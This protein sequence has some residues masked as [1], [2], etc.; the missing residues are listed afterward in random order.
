VADQCGSGCTVSSVRIKADY[1]SMKTRG[2][3]AAWAGLR[4]WEIEVYGRELGKPIPDVIS[5]EEPVQHFHNGGFKE[6]LGQSFEIAAEV[7]NLERSVLITG[8]SET[9]EE[10]KQGIHTALMG[11]GVVDMRYARLE[12]CGQRDKMGRY[13]M[14]FHQAERCPDCRY[15]GNAVVNSAQAAITL[16]GSHQ[17]LVDSNIIWKSFGAG[18]Y[19]EDGNEMNN[20]ISANVVVCPTGPLTCSE[21]WLGKPHA[22]AGI[23]MIGMT[24]DLIDNRVAGFENCIWTAGSH[25]PRGQGLAL[26]KV[27][28]MHAPFGAIRGNVCHDNFRFGLYLDNQYPR[29]LER[30]SNGM[31]TKPG[32]CDE[33]KPDGAD[34]GVV[35]ANV[36]EDEFDYHNMFVGQYSMGDVAFLRYRSLNNAHSM[37]WKASKNFADGVSHHMKDCVFANDPEDSFGILQL[38][39]PSGPFVF[40]FTNNSFV[41]SPV[42]A[43]A[44]NAGQHCGKPGAGGPCNVQYYLENINWQGLP[45]NS[46]RIRFGIN[47]EDEAE[48]LPVFLSKD[49]SLGGA[50]AMVSR[51]MKGFEKVE[52]CQ[53]M[54]SVWDEGI[55]CKKPVRRLNIWTSDIGSVNISGPGFV[56]KEEM[57]KGPPV[58]GGDA[59]LLFFENNLGTT[60]KGYGTMALVGSEY[61]V[62]GAWTGDVVFDFSDKR[63]E[64]LFGQPENVTL[65]FNGEVCK[66][67]ASDPRAFMT[68]NGPGAW[69]GKLQMPCKIVGSQDKWGGGS[70]IVPSPSP[71]PTPPPGRLV[72][73]CFFPN[74]PGLPFYWEPTCWFGKIGCLGDGINVECRFCGKGDFA[75]IPCPA[76]TATTTAATTPST[77]RTTPAPTPTTATATTTRTATATT[78]ATTTTTTATAAVP[79]HAGGRWILTGFGQSCGVGCAGQGMVCE[80]TAMH[81]YNVEIDSQQEM[82]A[83][84]KD[85]G[86]ECTGYNDGFGANGDVP[87]VMIGSKMCFTSSP[88]RSVDSIKCSVTTPTDRKRLCFCSPSGN[89]PTTVAP[90]LAPVVPQPT[91]APT[92]AP[93][94][95]PVGDGRWALAGFGQSCDEGCAQQGLSCKKENF[96][97]RNAEVDSMGEMTA[98]VGGLGA[99]CSQYND[100]WGSAGD[101]PAV[102]VSKG[103]CFLSSGSRSTESLSCSAQVSSDKKRLCWCAGSS[104]ATTPAPKTTL[105]PTP[106]P[107]PVATPT[108]QVA[109]GRWS[110][111][112]FGQSC[113]QGCT[114]QGLRCKQEDFHV[115]NAEVD[116]MDEMAAIV[117]GLGATCS[118]YNNNWGSAGDV[119]AVLVSQGLCFVSGGLRSIDSLSCATGVSSDKKRLCWCSGSAGALAPTTSAPVPAPTLAPT[120]SAPVPAPAPPLIGSGSGSSSGWR[121]AGRGQ[122]CEKGCA[123]QGLVCSAAASSGRNGEIDSRSEMTAVVG[124]LGGACKWFIDDWGEAGD[125]PVTMPDNNGLCFLTRASRPLASLSCAATT[126][127]DKQ[128]LCFCTDAAGAAAAASSLAQVATAASTSQDRRRRRSLTATSSLLPD[129]A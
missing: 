121:L 14:H 40:M 18:I 70:G 51:Y 94:P 11:K 108:P 16:H 98:I 15:Q 58:N 111:A 35:P 26:G 113:E 45:P 56:S 77:A 17:T 19:T 118:Q 8:D 5:L 103:M 112:A 3:E 86:A 93:A 110:L 25:A 54:D 49:D 125:V 34:N 73:E 31:L 9:F 24:N 87:V 81:R 4:I 83:M 10:T 101:V 47:G 89:G 116:S 100:Q 78:T 48:V 71:A 62:S 99:T 105:A 117:K 13:C 21:S 124:A 88:T 120:T 52:G 72:G 63:L 104:I 123:G 126:G 61:T 39:G 97:M 107:V 37:Y 30:D 67:S 91:P 79:A 114:G 119:P 84:V 74:R 1:E 28:P 69:A 6:I 29:Q 95:V 38:L 44:L 57:N 128:R 75:S 50:R 55:A 127:A 59:G 96:H 102:L 90:T 64:S 2:T 68:A 129:A 12:N 23:Y 106:A 65:K 60:S 92:S 43:A 66:A 22:Q 85:L 32:S 109:G 82:R 80:P 115:R 20:M 27:C 122:S 41:G 36:V 76:T 53:K 7:V 46:K 33:F 42:G